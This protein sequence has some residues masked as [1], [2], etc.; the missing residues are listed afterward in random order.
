LSRYDTEVTHTSDDYAL[1]SAF[2]AYGEVMFSDFELD[3]AKT[4]DITAHPNGWQQTPLLVG[5][6]GRVQVEPS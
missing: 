6:N 3:P 4:L 5:N 1:C 2:M